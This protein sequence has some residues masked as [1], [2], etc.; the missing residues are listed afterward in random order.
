MNAKRL[1]LIQAL[2]A[3]AALFSAAPGWAGDPGAPYAK[4]APADQYLIA[5]RNA[6]IAMAR[7]AAPPSI[8]DSATVLILGAHGFETAIKGTNAF[9]CFVDRA[10]TKSF[11]DPEFW[12][13]KIRGPM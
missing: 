5:D 11:D 10:W 6:E 4:M 3:A 8:S 2:A 9:T 7:S 13:P 1:G 12:N